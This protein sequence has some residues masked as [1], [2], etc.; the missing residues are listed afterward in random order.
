MARQIEKL[1]DAR[2]KKTKAPGYHFDGNG[3][4]LQVSEAGT[5][6][7]IFRYTLNGKSREMG[8]GAFPLISL[9]EARGEATDKRKLLRDHIDPIEARA[10]QR[11]QKRVQAAKSVLFAECAERYIAAHRSGWRNPKHAAQ[12]TATIETYANPALGP[13]PVQDV[14]TGHI[15]RVLEPIWSTKPE[16]ASRLRGRIERILDWAKGREYRSGDNPARWRG[17]LENQLA[18]PGKVRRVES[19]AA[20]P[21]SKIAAFMVDLRAQEGTAARALEFTILD[22]ARTGEA[23]GAK[24]GEFNL[25]ERIWTIPGARMKAGREHRVPLSARAVA[26]VKAELAAHPGGE[27]VFP[28]RFD[29]TALSNMAML[30][31]LKRMGHDDITVHGFRSTFRDWAA[32]QTSYPHDMCEMALAHVQDDKTVAAYLRTDMMEKRR[33]LMNDWAKYCDTPKAGAKVSPIRKAAAGA[34]V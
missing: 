10:A 14:A 23:I 16:T 27:Y 33:R 31:L 28:G 11:A 3:L 13:M 6:S 9:A 25:E 20:L 30:E 8:L 5:K 22:A 29:G 32:E 7:W 34:T 17:H 2:V 18:K 19:H 12:W 4:Y 24:P 1:N 21:Y 26:I 15:L